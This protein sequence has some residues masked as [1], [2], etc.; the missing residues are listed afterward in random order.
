MSIRDY[1]EA[2]TKGLKKGELPVAIE[3][4]SF[5]PEVKVG[6]FRVARMGG[7]GSVSAA[8][9]MNVTHAYVFTIFMVTILTSS[10]GLVIYRLPLLRAR[11]DLDSWVSREAAFLANNLHLGP[12]TVSA[13]RS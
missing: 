3:F 7:K 11:H 4:S 13:R 10:F 5:P 6:F 2:A 12:L 9:R 1:L 8:A